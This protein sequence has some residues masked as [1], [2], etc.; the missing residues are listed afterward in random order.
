MKAI[1][2]G[3]W[4]SFGQ[5]RVSTCS[6]AIPKLPS[7]YFPLYCSLVSLR[8][9]KLFL[10]SSKVTFPLPNLFLEF[11]SLSHHFSLCHPYLYKL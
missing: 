11:H 7:V 2:R 3:F 10:L 9:V 5:P 4:P 6:Q 1:N 8:L